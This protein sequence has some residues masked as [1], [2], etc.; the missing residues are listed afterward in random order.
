VGGKSCAHRVVS[1]ANVFSCSLPNQPPYS[2][3]LD[4]SQPIAPKLPATNAATTVARKGTLPRSAPKLAPKTND[5][6]CRQ[7]EH[8][9]S[10]AFHIHSE[11]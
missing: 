5:S 4:T 2:I 9:V 6:P 3:D 10:F 1:C 11:L 8:L 7:E